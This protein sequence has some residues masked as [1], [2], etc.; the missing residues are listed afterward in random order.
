M[1]ELPIEDGWE[2]NIPG[3]S[4]IVESIYR[5]AQGRVTEA[6]CQRERGW[7]SISTVMYEVEVVYS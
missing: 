6:E 2:D 7:G 4:A 5:T 3:S 1:S